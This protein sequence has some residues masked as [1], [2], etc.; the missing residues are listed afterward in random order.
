[1]EEPKVI[2]LASEEDKSVQKWGSVPRSVLGNRE[3]QDVIKYVQPYFS[4]LYL[5]YVLS[6]LQTFC[7]VL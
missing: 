5:F 1:M 6:Y 2:D 4:E 3:E 7:T